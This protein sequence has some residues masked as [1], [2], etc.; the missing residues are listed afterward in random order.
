M[1]KSGI[2]IQVWAQPFFLVHV[3]I[4]ANHMCLFS[5]ILP[6]P[7]GEIRDNSMGLVSAILSCPYAEIRDNRTCLVSV[8]LPC[9]YVEIRDNRTGLFLAIL[10]CPCRNQGFFF[11]NPMGLVSVILPVHM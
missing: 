4:N 11:F 9:P 5:A 8:I 10:S 2:I 1:Q 7:Y 3:E 6:C